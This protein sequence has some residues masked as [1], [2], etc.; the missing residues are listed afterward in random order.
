MIISNFKKYLSIAFL[1]LLTTSCENKNSHN[2]ADPTDPSNFANAASIT[3]STQNDSAPE[4][5][6]QENNPSKNKKKSIYY[7]YDPADVEEKISLMKMVLDN[8]RD[9]KPEEI[10]EARTNIDGWRINPQILKAMMESKI[11]APFV[12]QDTALSEQNYLSPE[13]E[14]PLSIK[15]TA[16]S[17]NNSQSAS[18]LKI[19]STD[20]REFQILSYEVNQGNCQP[21]FGKDKFPVKMKFGKV[22]QTFLGCNYSD[23]LEVK[24]DTDKGSVT[25]QSS[26]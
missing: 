14:N 16:I 3:L 19:Q 20:S 2:P 26:N 23:I 21:F 17:D 1:I 24:I 25:L 22:F 10:E 11:K 5:T 18:L 12:E 8:P 13:N 7:P 6:D 9:Y 15:W 4:N